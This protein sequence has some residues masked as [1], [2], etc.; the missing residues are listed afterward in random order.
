MNKKEY[1]VP[2]VKMLKMEAVSIMTA[3]NGLNN[4]GTKGVVPDDDSDFPS[5]SPSM[6]RSIRNR[7][8]SDS[9]DNDE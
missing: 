2:S 6:G 1:I 9:A 3:S 5:A 4:E 8:S 7:F